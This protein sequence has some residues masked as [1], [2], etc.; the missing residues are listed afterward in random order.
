[1][2]NG[3]TFKNLD[4]SKLKIGIVKARWNSDVIAGL[5]K[6]CMTALRESG[7][8]EKN[9]TVV[10]V[11]GAFELPF[12]AKRLIERGHLDAVVTIGAVI[13]GGTRHNE[14]INVAASAGIRDVGLSTGTPVIFGILTCETEAQA[15]ERSRRDTNYGYWWGKSAVEMA[16][17]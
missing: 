13:K 15:M 4:G 3:I 2:S 8:K 12:G 10:E 6:G 14:Y 11:P 17:L 9:V 16:L 1:M 7:V 5:F